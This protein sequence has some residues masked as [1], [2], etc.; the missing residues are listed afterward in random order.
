M[1]NSRQGKISPLGLICIVIALSVLIISA[2]Y[3][4]KT[5]QELRSEISSLHTEISELQAVDKESF[6]ILQ[7]EIDA[8]ADRVHQC[9]DAIEEL[10]NSIEEQKATIEEQQEEIDSLKKKLTA[11]QT[12]SATTGLTTAASGT[13]SLYSAAQFKTQGVIRWN[14]WKWTW[15]TERILPGEGLKIPGRHTDA[16][17]W[18]RDSD[19]YLCLASSTLS[20]GTIID[21]PFGSQ[22]KVYDCGCAVGTVDVYT[23]W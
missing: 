10:N 16:E 23:N 14:G 12:A 19:G 8:L 15:Y 6:K 2:I 21:T 20:K 13:V 18:V 7:E 3:A 1:T 5:T 9:D 11:K 4:V 17:G 22:G